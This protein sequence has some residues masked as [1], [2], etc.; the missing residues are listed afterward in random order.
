VLGAVIARRTGVEDT[1][2]LRATE[3]ADDDP[4]KPRVLE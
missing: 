4:V 3:P 1:D 2:R